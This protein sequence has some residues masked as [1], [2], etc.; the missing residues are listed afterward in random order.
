MSIVM[1]DALTV[2]GEITGETTPND[3]LGHIL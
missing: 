3:V 1:G 2:L